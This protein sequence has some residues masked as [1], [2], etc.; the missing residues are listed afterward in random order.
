M[1]V[2][3]LLPAPAGHSSDAAAT[4][5]PAQGGGS[6]SGGGAALVDTAAALAW[7]RRAALRLVIT[8]VPNPT[9]FTGG[10]AGAGG[11]LGAEA[12]REARAVVQAAPAAEAGTVVAGTLED[13]VALVEM[14]AGTGGV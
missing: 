11:S 5:A 13:A 14:L 9:A 6:G 12:L 8:L 10:G 2:D 3:D 7:R 1:Y 4:A